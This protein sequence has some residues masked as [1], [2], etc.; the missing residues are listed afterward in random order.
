MKKIKK[1][2]KL[3]VIF[4]WCL[5]TP[6]FGQDAF[7]E[8]KGAVEDEE[9]K[10][11]LDLVNLTV[12]GTN[13]STITNSE[14]EF[15]IKI[16]NENTEGALLISL[17]GY[18]SQELPISSLSKDDNLIRLAPL[19]TKLKE[20]NLTT[21]SSAEALVR[22]V[23]QNKLKNHHNTPLSMTAFY[24][25]NV[26]KRNKNVSLTEAVVNLYKRPYSSTY[27]DVMELYKARKT[28]DYKR[29]DTLAVKLRG[30]P[31][32][33]LFIDV[34]KYP[35]NI[36]SE[37][38]ISNYDYS[39]GESSVINDRPVYV[40][41]FKLKS[42]V[43]TIGYFGQM[44]IDEKSIALVSIDYQLDVSDKKRVKNFLVHK[45][46]S[47]VIA[48]P[49]MA[50]YRVDYKETDGKWYYSYSR[51]DLR[52]KINRKRQ[53]F[54]SVYNVSSEMAIT[55]WAPTDNKVNISAKNRLRST[56]II[57]DA[58]SGF[59]DPD[60]WGSYNLIEPDKSI[61]SAIDKIRR[62]LRRSSDKNGSSS[63]P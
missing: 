46:P 35:E 50:R 48:Y 14:G 36:F 55:D 11:S 6:V 43:Q 44:F 61:Q 23:F 3:G 4:M 25:E 29:L 45:K 1:Q 33:N 5:L 17:L 16:P 32:S 22:K 57:N 41:N 51:L 59:S 27:N 9:T 20:V 60:F 63:L 62:Q 52:F 38:S 31:F 49:T 12:K 58:I 8:Y 34:M 47:D 39:F 26:K 15:I 56:V 42:R 2:F 13:I 53:L 21:F 19:I 28:T 54:N 24:R 37:E 18:S 30:G 40:V 10:K 7:Q